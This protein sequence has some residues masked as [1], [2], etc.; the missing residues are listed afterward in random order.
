M[1]DQKN[2]E[3]DLLK[4]A[5]DK[6]QYVS[7]LKVPEYVVHSE[8]EIKGFFGNYRFLSNFYPCSLGIWYEGLKYPSTE[9]AYQ[10][11]KVDV[12]DRDK[13]ISCSSK[14]VKR[15][16]GSVS[17]GK[18]EWDAKKYNIM[19]QLVLQKFATHENLRELLVKTNNAYIE[20]T[21]HW[22]DMY[23]GVCDG[24]GENKLGEILMAVRS[25]WNTKNWV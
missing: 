1:K 12:E 5:L 2:K 22:H 14:D 13:F 20:E 4:K 15:L 25:F 23:W 8:K 10:A 16:G 7:E 17:I 21:N 9:H 18:E 6:K 11:A 24:K 3:I 19:A